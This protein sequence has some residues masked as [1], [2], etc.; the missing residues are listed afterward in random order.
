MREE[1]KRKGGRELGEGERLRGDRRDAW[2][3]YRDKERW[4]LTDGLN[5][6]CP[7]CFFSRSMC[8]LCGGGHPV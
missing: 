8:S 6:E 4:L 1:G 3:Q 2:H 5:L 7:N